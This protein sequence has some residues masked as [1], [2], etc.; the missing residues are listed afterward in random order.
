MKTSRGGAASLLLFLVALGAYLA[1]GRT[2]GAG[3]TLPAAYLPW[4]L[5]RHGTFDL[6]EFRSLYEGD[7]YRAFPLLDGIPYYLQ[8]RNGR[9]LSAYGPGVGVLAVP[10]YAPFVLAGVKPDPIWADRLEKLAAA[11][12]TALSALVLYRAL[13]IVTE[14]GWAFVIGLV[15]ALGTSSL[16]VSS[17]GLWQHGPSQLFLALVLYCLVKGSSDDRYLG[18]A[19]V[20]MAA[21]VAMRS[22]DLLLVLPPALWILYAHRRRARDLVLCALVPTAALAAYY[23]A[24]VGFSDRGLGHTSAPAWAL[25]VQTPLGEGVPG[26][27]LSPSR[28]LFVYSPVLV[29]SLI[30][31]LVVWRRGSALSRA[32]TVGPPLV[33]LLV[34]KWVTWWGGHSWGPRLLADIG[35]ILCFFLY[36]VVSLLDRR[37]L[38]KAIFV[39]LTV[40]SIG[41]HA[42]GAWLYDRRWD[43]A[44]AD[45]GYARLWPWAGSALDFYGRE[46]LARAR[47][48]L[49]AREIGSGEAGS[50]AAAYEAGPAP[51]DVRSGER[52]VL[53][54]A[55]RNVG[56]DVW[57]VGLPGERGAVLLVWR[58][59]RGERDVAV[60]SEGLLSDVRP[61]HT[62][63]FRARIVAPSEPGD[64][65]LVLDLVSHLVTW[66]ADRGHAPVRFAVT[67]RPRDVAH[68]LSSPIV[69]ERPA[70]EVTVATDRPSYRRGETLGLT[71]VSE[72]PYRP[73]NLDVYLI[74]ERPDGGALFF[75]G[76]TPPRSAG[77]AWP[78]WVR[79]LPLP[80]W[81]SGRFN[82]P[83][84]ALDPGDY[85]WHV[86]VTEPG[87]FRA[88]ARA[89]A[90]FRLE[91]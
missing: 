79:N 54:L 53:P 39:L 36:P 51:G 28:G 20:P 29:F 75:D 35:P 2:L 30:G 70:P 59:Y 19:G 61:G 22:T 8:H 52:F 49:G 24:C 66:F 38:L 41:A 26:I 44:A 15:Y 4:T 90:G 86:V 88:V 71:V 6:S 5:L 64:Y 56:T 60:G 18:Y 47:R 31:M 69:R 65:T 82:V 11:L 85:R 74:L 62:V 9:Y 37:W 77:A 91:P 67:V 43:S 13:R 46:A 32:L 68:T 58:W 48:S 42:L 25:F 87:A 17:Q 1:N 50:L 7:A 21:A 84:T 89:T 27:L 80:G 40:W 63:T 83:L 3:D 45:V 12:I 10:V 55:A 76:H 23:G 57:R 34:G 33:V 81:A 16:S 14:S 78:P 72:F 73:R